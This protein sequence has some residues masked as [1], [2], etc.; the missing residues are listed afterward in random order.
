MKSSNIN[1]TRIK[2][3]GE[4]HYGLIET[5]TYINNNSY[6]VSVVGYQIYSETSN[7]IKEVYLKKYK[8]V[9]FLDEE[10]LVSDS[11]SKEGIPTGEN[12]LTFH[13]EPT[14]EKLDCDSLVVKVIYNDGAVFEKEIYFK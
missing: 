3:L 13:T 4:K 14:D 5:Y 11:I 9:K 10:K 7:V 8:N 12:A 2:N 1:S 6:T